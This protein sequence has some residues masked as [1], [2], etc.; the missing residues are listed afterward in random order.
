MTMKELLTDFKI[1]KCEYVYIFVK[2]SSIL[3][4]ETNLCSDLEFAK[5]SQ[6]E[7][8]EID[9]KCKE[10]L[11]TYDIYEIDVNF[12]LECVEKN[13]EVYG[14]FHILNNSQFFTI[15]IDLLPFAKKLDECHVKI[16][17]GVVVGDNDN[18]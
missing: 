16:V 2:E 7:V 4:Y 17:N 6:N 12:G 13:G 8:I 15:H 11:A 9:K 1:G 18:E 10:H 5:Q 3:N 14:S